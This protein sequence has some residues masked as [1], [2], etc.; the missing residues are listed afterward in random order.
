M[1]SPEQHNMST[2]DLKKVH[3]SKLGDIQVKSD[4]ISSTFSAMFGQQNNDL[5]RTLRLREKD[6]VADVLR[7]AIK[8]QFNFYKDLN[9]NWLS[10]INEIGFVRL[11]NLMPTSIASE[12]RKDFENKAGAAFHVWID[13]KEKIS[14][15][16]PKGHPQCAFSPSDVLSNDNLRSLFLNEEILDLVEGYLGAPGRLFHV[17][18]MCSF[19]SDVCGNAQ[20]FH[21]DNSHPIFCVLFV[22]LSDVDIDSGA[23]QYFKHTHDISKFEEHYPELN[24]DD[25]FDLPNDSYGFDAFI[26]SALKDSEET[27]TG[28]A[29]TCFLSDPRGLHRGLPPISGNRWLAWA[30]YALIPDADLIPK[31]KLPIDL[32]QNLSERQLYCLS[33]IVD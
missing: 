24:S 4:L 13:D 28:D 3:D 21:R 20:M 5:V 15:M 11:N 25:F 14:P 30:R 23:H 32:T 27:I 22:Y 31:V 29:G 16:S 12:I 7:K 33:S 9:P 17:N 1:R 8:S 18:A 26:K 2:K 10:K 19:P 6:I